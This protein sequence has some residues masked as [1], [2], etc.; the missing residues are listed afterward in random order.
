MSPSA[1][2]T[3]W[4][5]VVLC[6]GLFSAAYWLSGGHPEIISPLS[7]VVAVYEGGKFGEESQTETPT[8]TVRP[9]W[10]A[11]ID[12]KGEFRA[13]ELVADP[14][15]PKAESRDWY[16]LGYPGHRLYP[17]ET[18]KHPNG[19]TYRVRFNGNGAW[20]VAIHQGSGRL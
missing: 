6:L 3:F 14:P 19:G 10:S 13:I 1:K 12:V 16:I 2:R 9:D 17:K 11:E 7:D 15:T 20:R 5:F 4:I 18:H 8:F